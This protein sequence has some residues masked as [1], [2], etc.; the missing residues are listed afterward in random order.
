MNNKVILASASPR[1]RELLRL[2]VPE[3]EIR[4]SS[5]DETIN[6]E[7]TPE[8]TVQE[9]ARRKAQAI[10]AEDALIIGAD[11]MVF[12]DGTALGKPTDREDA[13]RMLRML[14]GRAHDVLTGV[15]IREGRR[16][17]TAA[18]RTKVYFS[19]MTQ[20]EIDEYIATG[21]PM[22][23]AGAYGIQGMASRYIQKIEGC[24]F[25]VVGLPVYQ[26]YQMLKEF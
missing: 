16:L 12:V 2:V 10:D 5:A 15:C 7:W 23:K 19:A 22:D 26:L 13:A 3:F 8:Q 24:F 4:V 20:A 14:S 11:T 9:L 18:E 25:N 1:R 17:R 6:P 21:E